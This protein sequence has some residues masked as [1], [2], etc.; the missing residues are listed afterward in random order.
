MV[1]P[2]A[3]FRALPSA[4]GLEWGEAESGIASR[5]CTSAYPLLK[6]ETVSLRKK[7]S[8]LVL[9]L[10]AGIFGYLVFSHRQPLLERYY[11]YRLTSALGEDRWGFAAKLEAIGSQRVQDWY[12]S[13][14]T[15]EPDW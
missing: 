4:T 1:A 3:K 2:P 10:M 9:L 14:L 11:L 6:V 7:L 12:L 13:Q 8:L 5:R 15:E